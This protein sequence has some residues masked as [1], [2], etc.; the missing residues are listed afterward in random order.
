MQSVVIYDSQSARRKHSPKP[1]PRNSKQQAL[2]RSRML[3]LARWNY[4]QISRCLSSNV[5]R[6]STE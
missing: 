5:R 4:R 1:L 6:K 3:V 2:S